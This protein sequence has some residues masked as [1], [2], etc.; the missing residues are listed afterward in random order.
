MESEGQKGTILVIEDLEPMLKLTCRVLRE[1]G[2][3]V[4]EAYDGQEALEILETSPNVDLVFA[5]IITPRMDGFELYRRLRMT[6]PNL[7]VVL[8]SVLPSLSSFSHECPD[9]DFIKKSYDLSGLPEK[10]AEILKSEELLK[11]L[12]R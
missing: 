10:L 6:H 12:D 7:K 8:T 2:F 3:T 11:P 4:I 1:A 5:D 9:C